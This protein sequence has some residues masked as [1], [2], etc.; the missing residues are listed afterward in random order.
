MNKRKGYLQWP[1]HYKNMLEE[2]QR[3]QRTM[4][5]HL[6]KDKFKSIVEKQ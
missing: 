6:N 5:L 2:E 4:N 3:K 1:K